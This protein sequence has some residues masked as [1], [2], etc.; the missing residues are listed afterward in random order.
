MSSINKQTCPRCGQSANERQI[1]LFTGMVEALW[2]VWQWCEQKGVHEFT[3]KEIKHLLKT[4]NQIA[5][6]GDWVLFGGLVYRPDGRKGVYGINSQRVKDFFTGVLRIP[7]TLWKNPLTGEIKQEDFSL[8]SQIPNLKQ[9]L[10]VNEE[11]IARYR[12]PQQQLF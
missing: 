4:D 7:R 5:R 11:F 6:F 8:I 1:A 2:Q 10:D 12:E 3:R 9:F